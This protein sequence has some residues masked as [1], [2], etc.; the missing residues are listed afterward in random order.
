M[1][2]ELP[3]IEDVQAL[4]PLMQM[5]HLTSRIQVVNSVDHPE[6]DV[7]LKMESE[8]PFGSYKMRGVRAAVER[9]LARG[10]SINAFHT[11]SAG[12][13]AQAV[14]AC[15]RNMSIPAVALV[16]DSAPA[17]KTAAIEALGARLVQKPMSA[18]WSMVEAPIFADDVLLIHPLQTPGILAGYGTIA[19]E[20]IEQVP[21]C[22]AVFI[23][24]GVGGLT[25]GIAAILRRIAPHIKIIA[26]ETEAA[27]TLTAAR[28][29]GGPV[30]FQKSATIAD[31]IGTPRV[32]PH[33]FGLLEEMVDDTVVVSE[34]RLRRQVRDLYTQ[35]HLTVEGA[36][37]A[38]AAAAADSPFMSPVAIITGKNINPEILESI[39]R[40]EQRTY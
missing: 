26:V 20:L 3:M 33:V 35:H 12:N 6:R 30:A 1:V 14:A 10:E 5:E 37:A 21:N 36:A 16:P 18:I 24:F 7:Y 40:D 17:I 19:L 15:A 13:M 9:R 31:A 34:P 2:I 39:V 32:V 27:P 8:L 29:H 28:M 25:L 38:A 22:D 23:P 11:I 4:L